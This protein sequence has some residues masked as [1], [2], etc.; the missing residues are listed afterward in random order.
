MDYNPAA[1]RFREIF[2]QGP[3]WHFETSFPGDNL[4][5]ITHMAHDE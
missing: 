1:L 3:W 4:L 5:V 2:L